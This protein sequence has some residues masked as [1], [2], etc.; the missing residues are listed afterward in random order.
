[1]KLYFVRHGES[2]ANVL[3]VIANRGQGPALTEKG[4]A[5][6]ATLAE[7]LRG[8]GV[9]RV[10]TSPLLRG[11]QTGMI[12]AETLGVPCTTGLEG[13]REP[14]CGVAEDRSDAEAWA[15]NASMWEQWLVHLRWDYRVP[16]GESFN[17]V[18][19]RFVPL[20]SSLLEGGE[21]LLL[22]GHG[23]LYGSMLPLVLNNVT[24]AWVAG[25]ELPNTAYVVAESGPGGLTCLEWNGMKI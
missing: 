19:H 5:Q 23:M 3:R 11:M 15:L 14:D 8:V 4:R 12:L 25:R 10:V 9:A 13:L 16:G 7:K 18:Q 22:V 2:E 17:D 1:V 21:D 6:A 20:L 24:R